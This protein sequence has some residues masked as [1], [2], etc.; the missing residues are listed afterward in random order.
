VHG[1]EEL[2]VVAFGE[3]AKARQR[4]SKGGAEVLATMRG[5]EDQAAA[6]LG[7]KAAGV[8]ALGSRRAERRSRC[9]R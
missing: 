6:G 5:D 9:C 3:I 7:A 2:D 8:D 1:V 4:D